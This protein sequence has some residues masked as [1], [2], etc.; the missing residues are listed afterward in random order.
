MPAG[1]AEEMAAL[2]ASGQQVA[3]LRDL[4]IAAGHLPPL[5][6]WAKVNP[7]LG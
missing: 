1:T 6:D 2:Q 3:G 7:H 4:A 5:A